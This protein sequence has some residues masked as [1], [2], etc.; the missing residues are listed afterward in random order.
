MAA[1]SY[2]EAFVERVVRALHEVRLEA[3]VIGTVAAILHGA[4]IVT[5]DIDLLLR[6]TRRN[7]QK[8]GRL[9]VLLGGFG[10]VR[11]LED[12]HALV[13]AEGNVDLIFDAMPPD[14]G[15]ESVRSRATL[16]TIGGVT[17]RVAA[18]EDVIRSKRAAGRPKDRAVLP[19]LEQTARVRAALAVADVPQAMPRPLREAE[20]G[21]HPRR[22]PRAGRR[23]K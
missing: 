21:R 23:R 15:F 1:S 13:G 19:V 9:R 6:R 5:Q 7:E 10:R 22:G 12:V 14:L 2:D 3:V 20:V 11:V 16:M 17:I 8:I 18:L 4:P